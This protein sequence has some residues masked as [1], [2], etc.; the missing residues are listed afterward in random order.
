VHEIDTSAQLMEEVV[1]VPWQN[2]P[3]WRS[4]LKDF[5]PRMAAAVDVKLKVVPRVHNRTQTFV[6]DMEEDASAP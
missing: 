1:D 4:T 3:N 6:F 2:A 5:A